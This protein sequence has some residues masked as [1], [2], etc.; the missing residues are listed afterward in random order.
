MPLRM[1]PAAFHFPGLLSDAGLL[2]RI[3]L[4]F[5]VIKSSRRQVERG[6]MGADGRGGADGGRRIL[7]II[8]SATSVTCPMLNYSCQWCLIRLI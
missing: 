3:A 7:A 2:I 1:K 4:R 6:Q 8:K 5:P